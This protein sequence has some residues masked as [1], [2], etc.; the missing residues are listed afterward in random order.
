MREIVTPNGKL[1]FTESVLATLA[2]AAAMRCDAVLAT[3][4]RH[5]GELAEMLGHSGAARGVDVQLE[6]ENLEIT[7]GLVV[8]FGAH[9]P[10]VAKEV[11]AAVRAMIQQQTGLVPDRVHVRVQ[12]V[13]RLAPPSVVRTLE[14]TAPG[15]PRNMDNKTP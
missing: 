14:D 6:Q 12:G 2:G 11:D 9:I 1:V 7:V 8:R 13:R 15:S 4:P 3:A 5:L 10:T